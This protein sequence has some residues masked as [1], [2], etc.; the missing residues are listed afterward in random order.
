MKHEDHHQFWQLYDKQARLPIARA[1]RAASRRLTDNAMDADDM[2]AWVDTRVWRLLEKNGWPTFHDDPTPEA[3]VERIVANAATLARWAYL[4]LSRKHFRRAERER[5]YLNGMSRAERLSMVSAEAGK[6]ETSQQ[7][8][9]DLAKIA[10]ALGKKTSAQLAASW[11]EVSERRRVAMALGATR[12]EDDELI[13]QTTHGEMK[14]N[15]VQQMRSR[16]RKRLA[17][18]LDEIRRSTPLLAVGAALLAVT[19]ATTPAF[20]GE[21]SGGRRGGKSAMIAPDDASVLMSGGE[22]SGGRGGGAFVAPGLLSKGG[23]QS[24]GRGG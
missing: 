10:A 4:A 13:D 12:A 19:I 3:A 21:Q 23:E 17:G 7:V 11:P 24:G 14:E 2:A 1:C 15:T 18:V 16:A 5:D 22:Q 8:R 9:D 6:V 20:G